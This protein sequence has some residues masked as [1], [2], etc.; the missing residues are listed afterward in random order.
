MVISS[1][2]FLVWDIDTIDKYKEYL[3]FSLGEGW[4]KTSLS[5]TKNQNGQWFEIKPSSLQK[6]LF[7][8]KL[9]GSI[10]LCETINWSIE[11]I[12][13]FYDYWDWE[14]LCLNK[15]IKWDETLIDKY[16]SKI[17]FKALSSNPSVRWSIGLIQKY[18][19]NWDW[20]ELSTNNGINFDYEMLLR[21]CTVHDKRLY[22]RELQNHTSC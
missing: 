22:Y 10:S 13:K 5:L 1:Y 14:E 2:E 8:F 21:R 15:G 16:L 19:N 4:R 3:I 9:K 7:N 20:S 6:N 18:L 11:I 17:N 12:D